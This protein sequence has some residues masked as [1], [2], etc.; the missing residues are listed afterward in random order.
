MESEPGRIQEEIHQEHFRCLERMY[1]LAPINTYFKPA[2]L[3][4]EGSA[5]ISIPVRPEFFHAASAV[6]GS[7]YFKAL[8]DAAFFAC[9]SL[10]SDYFVLTISFNIY[11]LRPISSGEMR[12]FGRVIR[13]SKRLLVADSILTNSE[14]QEVGRGS[15][16]F[17]PSQ[18][19]LTAELGYA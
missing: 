16:T 15:G 5:E 1:L 14:G 6:H 18:I 17:M 19:P 7:L 3:I 11:L 12:A 4:S 13:H 10:V 8:D 9:N 2:I